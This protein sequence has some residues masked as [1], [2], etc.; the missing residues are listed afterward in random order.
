M[1]VDI[2]DDQSIVQSLS[3]F[4]AHLS[5]LA[6][7]TQHATKK[8]LV[9]LLDGI[10]LRHRSEG[11]RKFGDRRAERSA[12]EGS[13]SVVT[14]H[15]GRLKLYGKRHEDILVASVQF[16]VEKMMPTYHFIEGLSG[17]SNAF[18]I[19]RR[20]GLKEKNHPRSGVFKASALFPGGRA[21]RRSWKR[22]FWKISTKEKQ[23]ALIAETEQRRQH[24]SAS[25]QKLSEEKRRIL[26]AAENRRRSSL[27]E[28]KAE[29]EMPLEELRQSQKTMKSA[30]DYRE[31]DQLNALGKTEAQPGRRSQR[32][33][34][35]AVSGRCLCRIEKSSQIA[36]I[37]YQAQSGRR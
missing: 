6:D 16:D 12:R 1:F 29:G 33:A 31:A 4:S 28:G 30:R 36:E 13:L 15:Y 34:G 26:D 27:E 25:S 17:Q 24:L 7:V 14:T 18:E 32:R 19:A 9:L 20:F 37:P 22:R 35:T 3:T 2:G 11:R 21:D 23:E 8:S 5:K 10:R